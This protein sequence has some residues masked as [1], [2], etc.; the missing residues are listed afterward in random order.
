MVLCLFFNSIGHFLDFTGA[1]RMHVYISR[2]NWR[3]IS[4]N[5]FHCL[6]GLGKIFAVYK[7]ALSRYACIL[8]LYL[9]T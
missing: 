7:E 4:E 9:L 2:Q 1:Y 8:F 5:V 6:N 3:I